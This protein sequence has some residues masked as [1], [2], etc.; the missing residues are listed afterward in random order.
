MYSCF[1]AA[2]LR[3]SVSVS[4]DSKEPY[5][6]VAQGQQKG[7]DARQPVQFDKNQ[8]RTGDVAQSQ[9]FRQFLPVGTLAAFHLS[10][11][12][13]PLCAQNASVASSSP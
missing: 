7:R 2:S 9:R 13:Q 11:A 1:Q 8:R 5:A 6:R 4:L 10:K 12:R 3:A